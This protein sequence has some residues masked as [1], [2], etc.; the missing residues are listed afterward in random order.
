[1]SQN[2][3]IPG[4]DNKVRQV[5]TGIDLTQAL[6][7]QVMFGAESYSLSLTPEV[8][9]VESNDTLAINLK[10]TNEKG[11]V[12]LQVVYVDAV[13][14][15]VISS[16][17]QGTGPVIVAIGSLLTIE[18]GSTI[19][20]ANS[21]VTD[22]ELRTYANLR[23]VDL[24]PTQP[25]RESLLIKAMDYLFSIESKLQGVRTSETQE[26]PFP[27]IGVMGRNMHISSNTIHPDWKKAQMELAIQAHES[28]LLE[29]GKSEEQSS[30]QV[31]VI[32]IDFKDT[33]T[34]YE[35]AEAYLKPYYKNG[36]L[37]LQMV[38]V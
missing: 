34:K 4:K 20:N 23:F 11:R 7:I 38:R 3:V 6:D 32:S 24:P 13:K 21:L 28:E 5:Y 19:T 2:L 16:Q 22:E 33:S 14:S 25:E 37:G 18:D 12:Y 15:E 10:G 26:L 30:L 31:D 1:M 17:A 29:S 8:V 27:R 36:G 9:E 35:K